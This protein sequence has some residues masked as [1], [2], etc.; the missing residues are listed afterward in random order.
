VQQNLFKL[1][2]GRLTMAH[3]SLADLSDANLSCAQIMGLTSTKLNL[4]KLT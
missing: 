1:T 2:S 4:I 3:L